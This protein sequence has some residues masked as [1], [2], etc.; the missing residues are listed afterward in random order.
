MTC[1][2]MFSIRENLTPSDLKRYNT[3]IK[4]C[5]ENEK[6]EADEQNRHATT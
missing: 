2:E 4:I 1:K 3:C 6:G 5:P